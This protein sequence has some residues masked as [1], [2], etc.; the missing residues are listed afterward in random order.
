[1][2]LQKCALF[3]DLFC[4]FLVGF[5]SCWMSLN[6]CQRLFMERFWPEQQKKNK[7]KRGGTTTHQDVLCNRWLKRHTVLM[8]R[9]KRPPP[10]DKAYCV[11]D[12]GWDGSPVTRCSSVQAEPTAADS[13]PF[14]KKSKQNNDRTSSAG[15]GKEIQLQMFFSSLS[16]PLEVILPAERNNSKDPREHHLVRQT[17]HILL[18][19]TSIAGFNRKITHFWFLWCHAALLGFIGVFTALCVCNP[20]FSICYSFAHINCCQS[21]I[22]FAMLWRFA[23]GLNPLEG[24]KVK[25]DIKPLNKA[26]N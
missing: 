2:F 8:W 18:L 23:I 5:M 4:V 22:C 12:V 3:L 21:D 13:M 9:H 1:M 26:T 17:L 24:S 7:T 14:K 10:S 15:G 20:A 25:P 16:C 6:K 19:M 11:K